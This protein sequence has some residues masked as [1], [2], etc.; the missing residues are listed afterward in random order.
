MVYTDDA[1]KFGGKIYSNGIDITS[2][3]TESG[4]YVRM[5]NGTNIMRIG[6]SSSSPA[7]NLKHKGM[8]DELAI[9][10]GTELTQ[11]QIQDL[12]NGGVGKFYPNI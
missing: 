9:F 4:N 12:Y 7:A 8:I 1:S 10:N 5:I 3:H 6:N 2:L 11:L